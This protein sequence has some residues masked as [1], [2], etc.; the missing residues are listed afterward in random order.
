MFLT[1]HFRGTVG[2]F[3]LRG[4][5]NRNQC[6]STLIHKLVKSEHKQLDKHSTTVSY[7]ASKTCACGKKTM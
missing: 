3:F 5:R 2:Y 6:N 1:A 7:R 4:N